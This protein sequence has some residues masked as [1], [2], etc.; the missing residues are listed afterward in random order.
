[1]KELNLENLVDYMNNNETPISLSEID[2]YIKNMIIYFYDE[3]KYNF[4]STVRGKNYPII[5]NVNDNQIKKLQ[6]NI[7]EIG[8]KKLYAHIIIDLYHNNEIEFSNK[9]IPILYEFILVNENKFRELTDKKIINSI[10]NGLYSL[11]YDYSSHQCKFNHQWKVQ[12]YVNNMMVKLYKDNEII[13]YDTDIFF[14]NKINDKL[15]NTLKSFNIP[16]EIK[17]NLNAIFLSIKNM[18]LEDNGNFVIKHIV[19]AEIVNKLKQ[20]LLIARRIDKLKNIL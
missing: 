8:F 14:I 12:Q 3:F 10:L 5:C 16:Y 15:L 2:M 7:S 19:D 9:Y 1:M 20:R 4:N 11:S 18:I 17:N 6:H 13:A